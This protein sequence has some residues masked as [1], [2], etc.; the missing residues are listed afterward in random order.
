MQVCGKFDVRGYPTVKLFKNG[1]EVEKYAGP[2]TAE[3]FVSYIDQALNMAGG[4]DDDDAAADSGEIQTD[5]DM[6][7]LTD[8]NFHAALK[9]NPDM[10]V[11]FTA[12]WCGQYVLFRPILNPSFLGL[13]VTSLCLLT[14][15]LCPLV[16]EHGLCL[17]MSWRRCERMAT[18][19]R[20]VY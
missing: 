3:A 2:R 7:V 8:A 16:H 1:K 17:R 9:E 5:G 20:S 4:D 18:K 12:S 11:S 19:S 10:V 14:N 13:A 15:L 6:L